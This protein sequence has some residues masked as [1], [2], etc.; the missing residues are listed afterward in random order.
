MRIHPVILSGGSGTRLWPLSRALYPKQLLPL[1]SQ[2]TMLQETVGRVS[3]P[4]FV[5]PLVICNGEHRFI[6]AEQ[7]RAMGIRPAGIVLE[8]E[9]RNTAPAAAV[10]ALM[11]QQDDPEAVVML[12]PSDHVIRQ[13]QRFRDA[14]EAAAAAAAAGHLVTFGIEPTGP[15]TGYGYIRRGGPLAGLPGCFAVSRFVEKP[16]RTTAEGFLKTGEYAWNSG[17][18]LFGARD[19][20]EELGRFQP[21][22][23][24]SCRAAVA[25]G[26][27]DLDFFRLDGDAFAHSP[28]LSIDVAVMEK[29]D[30][31]AVV[32]AD[33]GWND[34][35]SWSALWELG[36][37]DS[38]G[39]VVHG[40]VFAQDV[41]GSYLRSEG[42]MLA[43]LGV[44]D[45]VVVVTQDAVLVAPRDRAQDVRAVVAG[46]EEKSRGEHINH[47]RVHRPWGWY[48]TVDAGP[49][50]QVKRICVNPGAK[51]SLQYHDHRAEHWVVVSGTA[52]IVHGVEEMVLEHN[53]S[54]YIP[55]G[56]RHRLENPGEEPLHIIEVQ[57]G[58]YLGEDDIV[59]LDDV[60]ART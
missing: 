14:I 44:E 36:E 54:T 13:R 42:P 20:L 27:R 16:D 30:R 59:R 56:V 29:T 15:E 31:A 8:P 50:F 43:A 38:A 39:N 1:V 18:F 4:P 34:V 2:E 11:A 6:V 53:Q 48:E 45:M 35:G 26:R 22:L 3:H 55:I 9:G 19:F 21:A 51:L 32:P 7:L 25:K 10:A 46:L 5:A 41:T 40:D 23:L 37:Q 58:D 57:S 12:L 17:M 49:L 28:S 52:R 33:L 24:D 60:Y 47:V